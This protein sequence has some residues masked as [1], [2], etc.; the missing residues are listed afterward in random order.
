ML[1]YPQIGLEGVFLIR[2]AVDRYLSDTRVV[3]TEAQTHWYPSS[4]GKCPRE[5]ILKRSGEPETNPPD[6]QSMRKF[7]LGE[8]V[9]RGLQE[10]V[11]ATLTVVGHELRVRDEEYNVS[12]K[13]D[14][15][16]K[17]QDGLIVVEYKS[18]KDYG[19]RFKPELPKADHVLQMGV[20][21]TFPAECYACP[22]VD[23]PTLMPEVQACDQCQGRRVF[24]L[25]DKGI[26]AYYNKNEDTI[27]EFTI[28][29]TDELRSGVKAALTEIGDHW[30]N[31]LE[32]GT[33]P[34]PLP[35]VPMTESQAKK[36]LP[37]TLLMKPDWRVRYCSYKNSGRCC[38]D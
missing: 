7:W 27:T 32:D 28:E 17:G 15:L 11:G 1:R 9:H 5:V 38:G 16:L 25:P 29:A 24:D 36:A 4:L 21:M 8:M 18:M 14:T 3:R 23:R 10:A 19:F 26:L 13:L 2:D 20:Y 31:F 6:E 37:G 34:E 35:M 12:G 30:K 22:K 33:L